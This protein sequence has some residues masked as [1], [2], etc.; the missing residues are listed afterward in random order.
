MPPPVPGS[1]LCPPLPTSPPSLG[2]TPCEARHRN[3]RET[4]VPLGEVRGTA[5]RRP[6]W[7]LL[8]LPPQACGPRCARRGQRGRRRSQNTF[9]AGCVPGRPR[10]Q[11]ESWEAP[12]P[13]RVP[14][15]RGASATGVGVGLGSWGRSERGPRGRRQGSPR[16]LCPPLAW[17]PNCLPGHVHGEP[18]APT[19]PSVPASLWGR[20][21]GPLEKDVH[22]TQC[23]RP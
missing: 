22:P 13:G 23:S 7:R 6:L 12:T 19:S 8:F 3:G 1:P 10:R 18:A 2:P 15:A 16:P 5:L 9:L 11:T 14:S 20:L 17:L 4:A 21:L